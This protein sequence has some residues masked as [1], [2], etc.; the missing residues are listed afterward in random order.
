MSPR[1]NAV[2]ET[3]S[4]FTVF[5]NRILAW[6]DFA[7]HYTSGYLLYLFLGGLK[8]QYHTRAKKGYSPSVIIT[9][10]SQGERSCPD[11]RLT[12]RQLM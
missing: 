8:P 1:T 11:T 5:L 3:F 12:G 10:A 9:G 2:L 6:L 7:V 4:N